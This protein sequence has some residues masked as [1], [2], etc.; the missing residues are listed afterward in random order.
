MHS[1][2][3]DL[4]R[5]TH[6]YP[7]SPVSSTPHH[8]EASQMRR[9]EGKS[10][11][12]GKMQNSSA[13]LYCCNEHNESTAVVLP[14]IGQQKSVTGN[15]IALLRGITFLE[16]LTVCVLIA[17]DSHNQRKLKQ[18][19]RTL[20]SE[21][22]H[23]WFDIKWITS[24]NEMR[25]SVFVSK[26]RWLCVKCARDQ[27]ACDLQHKGSGIDGLTATKKME[28]EQQVQEWFSP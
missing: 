25:V 23:E 19:V 28:D 22:I 24:L 2:G 3:W 1:G 11:K 4:L 7:E 13:W 8:A 12:D 5:T 15:V 20:C 14:L 10:A 17:I 18:Y 6:Y 27:Q 9:R 26:C 21:W 16:T